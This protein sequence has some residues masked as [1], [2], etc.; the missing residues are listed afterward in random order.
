MFTFRIVEFQTRIFFLQYRRSYHKASNM[1][2]FYLFDYISYFVSFFNTIFLCNKY[3][4]DK[5]NTN[6]AQLEYVMRCAIWCH[7]HNLR[8]VEN[9][10]GRVLILV[11]TLVLVLKLLH[12]CFSRFLNCTNDTKSRNASYIRPLATN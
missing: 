7:F 12:G 1:I 11:K 4:N 8:N 5:K 3:Y 6:I 9:T 10:Y 2:T